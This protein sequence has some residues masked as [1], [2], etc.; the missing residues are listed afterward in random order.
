MITKQH[1]ERLKARI[2]S[3]L[4]NE[5]TEQIDE[6]SKELTH[7]YFK[8]AYAQKY[9]NKP[10]KPTKLQM[11]NRNKGMAA[12]HKRLVNRLELP[13]GTDPSEGGKYTADSVEHDGT[14]MVEA[15]SAAVRWQKALEK[16]K[17]ER[18]EQERRNAENAKSA[19]T[20][21]PVKE[22]K[23]EWK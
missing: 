1:G 5:E 11:K 20:P 19:L 8:K 9:E 6:I 21:K 16:T 15:Q 18:E 23:L 2:K 7:S 17:R 22:D 14:P 13:K 10:S 4:S 12:A 3:S